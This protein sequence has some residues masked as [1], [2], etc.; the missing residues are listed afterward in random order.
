VLI[1]HHLLATHTV[2][3]RLLIICSAADEGLFA[4]NKGEG[5]LMKV[6][7]TEPSYRSEKK[8]CEP[9][10]ITSY[11]NFIGA[12]N[13]SKAV[14]IT[15]D[16]RRYWSKNTKVMQYSDE[17]WASLWALV[18]DANIRE[19]FFQ[20]LRTCV[21][22]SGVKIGRAPMTAAKAN[23]ASRQAPVAAKWLKT[24]VLEQP[25]SAACVPFGVGEDYDERSAKEDDKERMTFK[26]RPDTGPAMRNLCGDD[27]EEAA[28]KRDMRKMSKVMCVLP[29]SHISKMITRQFSGQS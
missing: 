7:I 25:S 26:N 1:S 4:G 29:L 27:Y 8:F 22:I 17:Q 21:D 15:S 24:A 16:D 10:N 14:A 13:H 3:W 2:L 6:L 11:H 19:I 18:H 20:Y 23:A 9:L 12:S 5:E 28:V